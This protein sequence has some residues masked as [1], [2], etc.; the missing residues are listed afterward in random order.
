MYFPCCIKAPLVSTQNNCLANLHH[1][2][3]IILCYP[4]L[5]G[6]Q[7]LLGMAGKSPPFCNLNN[8]LQLPLFGD[9]LG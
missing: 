6:R 8:F 7:W 3:C 2:G 9:I 4:E 1:Q 5:N